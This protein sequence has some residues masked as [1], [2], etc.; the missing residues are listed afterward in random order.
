MFHHKP[1]VGADLPHPHSDIRHV[2]RLELLKAKSWIATVLAPRKSWKAERD[3]VRWS[4]HYFALHCHSGFIWGSVHWCQP[5]SYMAWSL[6]PVKIH[7]NILFS[8]RKV[9][10][11]DKMSLW[12]SDRG[13]WRYMPAFGALDC[14][15]AW[16]HNYIFKNQL[17]LCHKIK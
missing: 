3:K 8:C 2:P 4:I 5:W 13:A 6:G 12:L 10:L 16:S 9:D 14:C 7:L 17:H 15:M 1:S 11:K